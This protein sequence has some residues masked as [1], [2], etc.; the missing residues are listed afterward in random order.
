M[1][2]SRI[3]TCDVDVLRDT[4]DYLRTMKRN[5]LYYDDAISFESLYKGLKKSCR[6]VRWKDSVVGYEANALINT[7]KLNRALKNKTYKISKYQTFTI[8]EPK[9]RVIIAS[10]IVDRQVQRALCD[11][12]LYQDITE[13]FI[14]DNIACQTNRG[15]DDV[16]RR[17]KTHLRRYYNKHGNQGWVLRCD[18]YHFF[19]E[20]RHD[21]A[22][23]A[24][25]KYVRDPQTAEYVELVIDSFEGNKGIGLGSQISQLVQLTVLNDMDH[26]IKER[27]KI[28][29]YIRYMD[30]FVLIHSDKEYLK[31]CREQL[32]EYISRL[33]FRF[34]DK[35]YIHPLKQGI[36]FLKWKFA[37]TNSGKV[38]MLMTK[39]KVTKAKRHLRKLYTKEI[40]G[41]VPK[42][43]TQNSFCAW[44]ANA[45][46]GNTYK[47]RQ[48]M[49]DYYYNLTHGGLN[50]NRKL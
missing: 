36:I 14:R 42:G 38:L 43:S 19:P 25:R 35:T 48:A 37:I 5:D 26:F 31:Y 34:N 16:F 11:S 20:T 10:R 32:S 1:L 39:G 28:K 41:E 22:K 46:R 12:G 49:N 40:K 27:L 21:I 17:M 23:A 15:T 6:N 9:K 8:T 3:T 29:Y 13:H 2:Q 44:I 33:G 50:V 30:D 45:K 47:I 18:I 7:L 24:V 4:L